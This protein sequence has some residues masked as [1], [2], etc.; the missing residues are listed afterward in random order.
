M[1]GGHIVDGGGR[2]YEGHITAFVIVAC[3]VAATGGLI[4]GYDIGISGNFVYI[5]SYEV[6]KK[7]GI[8]NFVASKV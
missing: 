4:F 3:V 6:C 8:S 7:F 2:H 5:F 1:A